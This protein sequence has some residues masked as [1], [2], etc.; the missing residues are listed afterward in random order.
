MSGVNLFIVGG[1]QAGFGH[2]DRLSGST[3]WVITGN[4]GATYAVI[5]FS[6]LFVCS[7][8]ISWGPW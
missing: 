5:V 6:Y 1:L 7:F 8:A 2:A 3:T 4:T